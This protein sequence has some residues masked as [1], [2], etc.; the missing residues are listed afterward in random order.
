MS[1]PQRAQTPARA[2]R[3]VISSGALSLLSVAARSHAEDWGPALTR[4]A[5]ANVE[6]LSFTQSLS[7]RSLTLA[8]RANDAP[9]A[10]ECL[11]SALPANAGADTVPHVAI[12]TPVAL[13]ALIC[14][15]GETHLMP[16]V[17][18]ALAR[19]G[20][21]VLSLSQSAS[22][23]TMLV[24]EYHARQVVQALHADLHMAS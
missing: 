5:E 23:I 13:V 19:T 10:R 11:Q 1:T 2:A 12:R 20:A 22:H 18:G 17:L 9:F 6:I 21:E 14:T 24:P 3:A 4:M 7:E 15:P 8:V 16:A